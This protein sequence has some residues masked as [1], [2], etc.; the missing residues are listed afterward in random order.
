MLD[1]AEEVAVVDLATVGDAFAVAGAPPAAAGVLVADVDLAEFVAAVL[2]VPATAG[3]T[4]GMLLIY[5]IANPRCSRWDPP[6]EVSAVSSRSLVVVSRRRL[7]DN[8]GAQ[9]L[10]SEPDRQPGRLAYK[11]WRPHGYTNLT[12]VNTAHRVSLAK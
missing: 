7:R 5:M 8:S 4:D 6:R 11:K 9:P 12:P 3:A 2:D 10:I 1:A